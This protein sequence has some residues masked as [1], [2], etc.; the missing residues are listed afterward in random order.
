MKKILLAAIFFGLPMTEAKAVYMGV[1]GGSAGLSVDGRKAGRNTAISAYVGTYVPFPVLSL[2]VGLE[3]SKVNAEL[4]DR[5]AYG[6][7]TDIDTYGL[8]V[9]SYLGYDRL[10]VVKPYVGIG[11]GIY[12]QES[13]SR[14]VASRE[15]AKKGALAYMAGFDIVI[16]DLPIALGL[17]YKYLDLT[18]DYGGGDRRDNKIDVLYTKIG[19]RF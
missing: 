4:E 3:Y 17:E 15:S 7:K 8:A 14:A 13:K 11:A 9:N 10:P 16:P 1:S 12:R 18:F 5:P 2:R 19:L 6:D